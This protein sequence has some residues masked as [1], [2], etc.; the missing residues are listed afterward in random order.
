MTRFHR[1]IDGLAEPWRLVAVLGIVAGFALPVALM[2]VVGLGGGV[3]GVAF[4][5]WMVRSRR[6]Y[7]ARGGK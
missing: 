5:W 2:P 1:W 3:V 4:G 7:L 6:R